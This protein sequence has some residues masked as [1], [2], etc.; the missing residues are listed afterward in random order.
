[1]ANHWQ[2][3]LLSFLNWVPLSGVNGPLMCET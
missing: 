1:L 2:Q 3:L